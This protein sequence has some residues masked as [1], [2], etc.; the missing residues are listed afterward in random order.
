MIFDIV[1]SVKHCGSSCPRLSEP[2][3]PLSVSVL[4]KDAE[5]SHFTS[6]SESDIPSH[7]SRKE[8]A[9]LSYCSLAIS[10][11]SDLLLDSLRPI[12]CCSMDRL[13]LQQAS[14]YLMQMF[15]NETNGKYQ[16]ALSNCG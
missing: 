2:Q 1:I 4:G 15:P 9:D 10:K 7:F 3:L 16:Q 8:P 5:E 11:F 13:A 6:C 12:I 14:G